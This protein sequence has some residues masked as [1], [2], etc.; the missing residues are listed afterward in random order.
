[1]TFFDVIY[2]ILFSPIVLFTIDFELYRDLLSLIRVLFALTNGMK[3]MRTTLDFEVFCATCSELDYLITKYLA[4]TARTSKNNSAFRDEIQ[5]KFVQIIRLLSGGGGGGKKY[6]N[7][8]K[9]QMRPRVANA[10]AHVSQLRGLLN[11]IREDVQQLEEQEEQSQQKQPQQKQPQQQSQPP[12]PPPP[13]STPNQTSLAD[14]VAQH[15][16]NS[17]NAEASGS[18]ADDDAVE[19]VEEETIVRDPHRNTLITVEVLTC[20]QWILQHGIFD[21]NPDNF[22]D[23]NG[24]KIDERSFVSLVDSKPQH[25]EMLAFPTIGKEKIKDYVER[26]FGPWYEKKERRGQMRKAANKNKKAEQVNGPTLGHQLTFRG[27]Y[28]RSDREIF[29]QFPM[30]S[31][32]VQAIKT[33]LEAR[34]TTLNLTAVLKL[35]HG[36]EPLFKNETLIIEMERIRAQYGNVR[37]HKQHI[38]RILPEEK[39]NFDTNKLKKR[40][41]GQMLIDLRIAGVPISSD[42]AASTMDGS[43]EIENGVVTR[44]YPSSSTKAEFEFMEQRWMTN[45]LS[46]TE[47]RTVPRLVPNNEHEAIDVDDSVDEEVLEPRKN[48]TQSE[49]DRKRMER[50][51]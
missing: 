25:P 41:L 51:K 22:V 43:V 42:L 12:P 29:R 50:K 18:R 15:S 4:F 33:F 44:I 6:N 45:E 27:K 28:I 11:E 16:S 3:Y 8:V 17:T 31:K 23:S 5:E 36:T 19:T 1:M 26:E 2:F 14:V 20:A 32:E 30:L 37:K 38:N 34:K 24:K 35:M 21:T 7:L 40:K 49:T 9:T 48:A 47:V 39:M 46:N 10:D 13:Q